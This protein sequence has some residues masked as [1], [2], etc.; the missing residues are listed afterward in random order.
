MSQDLPLGPPG[1]GE[2]PDGFPPPAAEE[3]GPEGDGQDGQDG[4][5]LYVCVRPGQLTLAVF[6]QNGE[7]DTMTPGPL[8]A[9]FMDTVT[10]VDGK[11]L[12]GCSDDQL[13]GVISA[14]R[15]QEARDAWTL[16]TAIAEFAARYPGT[17]VEDKFA[18]DELA[19]ELHLSPLSA[20]EQM[21]YATTVV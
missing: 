15:R 18:A 2:E 5:G 20:A 1:D 7:A 10:G 6:A 14:A 13:M 4:E 21:R 19:A 16:I 12:G 8:L 11:G 9:S 17:S 3:A